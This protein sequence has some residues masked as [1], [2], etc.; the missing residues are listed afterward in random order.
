[1]NI[2]AVWFTDL[3]VILKFLHLI[4]RNP[5]LLRIHLTLHQLLQQLTNIV[6]IH[7]VL[8]Y[9]ITILLL[10]YH[11]RFEV[12]LL[13]LFDCIEP[14]ITDFLWDLVGVMLEPPWR[15]VSF[16]V[17]LF[18]SGRDLSNR[19]TI[20]LFGLWHFSILQTVFIL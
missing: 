7:L 9:L 20:V 16:G 15:G 18:L 4:L 17:F 12:L 19:W 3:L 6:I 10:L 1:L 2:H 14:N 8:H 13:L 5:L 11:N